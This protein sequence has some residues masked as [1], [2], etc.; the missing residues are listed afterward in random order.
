MM[1]KD[2]LYTR[3]ANTAMNG[4][5]TDCP[6]HKL[7]PPPLQLTATRTGQ[8]SPK[9][10]QGG[11]LPTA[12][13][14]QSP[15]VTPS[16]IAPIRIETLH[17]TPDHRGKN[18]TVVGVGEEVD[19]HHPLSGKWTA[20][21]GIGKADSTGATFRWQ[22]PAVAGAARIQFMHLLGATSIDM[23]IVSP[24]GLEYEKTGELAYPSG[25]S[26]AGMTLKSE[27][28]PKYVC[29]S[30]VETLEHEGPASNQFGYYR[31]HQSPPHLLHHP[32]TVPNIVGVDNRKCF[33][34]IAEIKGITPPWSQGGFDWVIPNEYHV[35][36]APT[37]FQPICDVTQ[38]FRLAA[39]GEV[40]VSKGTK[41]VTRRP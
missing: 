24:D 17:D 8:A 38:S 1:E 32:S 6:G 41:S 4:S 10:G 37:P 26:A 29:F 7:A 18:R 13:P 40:T 39:S 23:E 15:P 3:Q 16:P 5:E 27:L 28:L 34:D 14:R 19:F 9:A 12:P 21:D 33:E 20:S 30:N 35:R 31:A 36:H 2:S 11:R 25:V 22:A